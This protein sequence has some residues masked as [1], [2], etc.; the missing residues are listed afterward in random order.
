MVGPAV[1]MVDRGLPILC[2]RSDDFLTLNVPPFRRKR[3]LGSSVYWSSSSGGVEVHRVMLFFG[4]FPFV[5]E[6]TEPR[7]RHEKG[8]AGG[9]PPTITFRPV[10]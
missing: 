5:A 7:D 1:V 6:K 4:G 10:G 9:V 8:H 2:R 3:P